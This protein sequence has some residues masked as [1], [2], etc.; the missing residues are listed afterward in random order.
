MMSPHPQ[1]DVQS[2]SLRDP[3]EF[4]KHQAEQL[5]WHKPPTEILTK[6][7]KVL[8]NGSHN[9]WEWFKGGEI[10]TCYNCVDRHVHAGNGDNVAII[11][12]SPVTGTK[13][14]YTYKQ[15][16]LEVETFAGV[17]REEGVGK[18][19]VVI[20]Y[21]ECI[22]CASSPSRCVQALISSVPMIPAA[23]VAILA[24]SRLGAIHAVV[25]G[26]FAA[27][28]LTQRIESSKPVAIITASAGIDGTKPP[29]S[30]QPL[31]REAID[32]SSFKPGK[33]IVWQREQLLWGAL[34]EEAGER[35]WQNLV[36][37]AK[38][39]G[40]KADCVPVASDDGV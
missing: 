26:G 39:R 24:I 12:D 9:H 35:D 10:S 29:L 15:L 7:T 3:E 19:D 8:R 20:L 27:A 30:Y 31:I 28:S 34:S 23:L 40:L 21:S 36:E 22:S 16:L 32:A 6:T 38:R 1:D 18:G 37:S 33:T 17:L 14:K 11:W 4:W 5:T 2:R 13:E 25:F